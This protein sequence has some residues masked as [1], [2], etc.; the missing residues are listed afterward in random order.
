MEDPTDYRS[1]WGRIR[2]RLTE[3]LVSLGYPAELGNI[4][5]EHIGS[6]K[7]IERMIYYLNYVRPAKVEL[8]ADEMMAIKSDID[9]WRERKESERANME[10]NIVLNSGLETP[11]DE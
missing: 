3:T 8:I 1:D 7:G 6:P 5:A 9:R 10:Y 4:I 2:D 11:E